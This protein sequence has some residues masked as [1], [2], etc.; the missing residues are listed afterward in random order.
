MRAHIHALSNAEL[1]E[2]E[3]IELLS[4]R[5]TEV[6]K[7]LSAEARSRAGL[8]QGKDEARVLRVEANL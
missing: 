8:K 7:A 4:L 6:L 3:R 1:A 5:R 2:A